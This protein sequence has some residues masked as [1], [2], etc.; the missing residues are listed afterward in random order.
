[1]EKFSDYG[2]QG[3]DFFTSGEHKAKCPK[4]P[5]FKPYKH[6]HSRNDKDLSINAD[7][8]TWY[9]F[10]CGWTGVLKKESKAWNKHKRCDPQF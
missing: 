1:M 6:P 9:C 2:I 4:C 7:K 10:R 5:T 3:V 8:K